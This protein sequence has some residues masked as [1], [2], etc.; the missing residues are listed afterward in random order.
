M[1]YLAVLQQYEFNNLEIIILQRKNPF[2]VVFQLLKYNKTVKNW[3]FLEVASLL[4]P[5]HKLFPS[6]S[7]REIVCVSLDNKHATSLT[8]GL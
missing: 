1:P 7:R 3:L 2:I 4:S 5:Q 6:A 8:T